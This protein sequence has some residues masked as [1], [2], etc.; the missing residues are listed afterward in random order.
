L[1]VGIVFVVDAEAVWCPAR[2][3]PAGSSL[4]WLPIKTSAINPP[5][6]RIAD[7]A[8]F[9]GVDKP[10]ED[11]GVGR[12]AGA[13]TSSGAS[14]GT[15]AISSSGPTAGI[16]GIEEAVLAASCTGGGTRGTGGGR[17]GSTGGGVT[18]FARPP[19]IG[20]P[21]T[22]SDSSYAAFRSSLSRQILAAANS[23]NSLCEAA[24]CLPD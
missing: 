23:F 13:G 17:G 21:A 2:F 5:T 3:A 24:E 12:I 1:I 18:S 7:A 15:T 6:M 14:S 19:L 4:A 8:S 9:A 20:G 22:R 16:G 10:G 11:G